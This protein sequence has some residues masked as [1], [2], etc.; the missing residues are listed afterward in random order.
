MQSL[1]IL[2]GAYF[3]LTLSY[4]NDELQV[5]SKETCQKCKALLMK[6]HFMLCSLLQSL[7]AVVPWGC[8]SDLIHVHA[9]V[10]DW[11][12]AAEEDPDSSYRQH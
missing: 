2:L 5:F 4:S 12:C 7:N 3:L 9:G 6:Q 1:W 11:V 10:L 8:C